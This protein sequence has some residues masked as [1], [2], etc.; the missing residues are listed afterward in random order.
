VS[1]QLL[2]APQIED[3]I[4]SSMGALAKSNMPRSATPIS[5]T[6]TQSPEARRRI[7]PSARSGL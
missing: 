5:E 4:T 6:A 1:V 7:S 2:T 3:G